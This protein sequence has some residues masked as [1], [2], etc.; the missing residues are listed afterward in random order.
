MSLCSAPNRGD[1][2]PTSLSEP[3]TA[4]DIPP[5]IPCLLL[6]EDGTM[7]AV[8][9]A[10]RRALEY[11]PEEFIEP[12]FF[13]H[14]HRRNLRRVM[15]DLAHMIRHGK[16]HTQWL[17]RLRTGTGRWRWYR[18]TVKNRLHHPEEGIRVRLRPLQTWSLS[19][20]K[21]TRPRALTMWG[22]PRPGYKEIPTAQ[23]VLSRL[24]HAFDVWD[25]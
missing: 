25:V 4:C 21:N 19:L 12:C 16:Q 20:E 9:G 6:D 24:I 10:S 2:Q 18:T 7:T 1:D 23:S 13:S 17:L 8:N 3:T 15:Q 14:V 22:N 5:H 11:C